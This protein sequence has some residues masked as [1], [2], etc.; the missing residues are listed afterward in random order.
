MGWFKRASREEEKSEA[1]RPARGEIEKQIREAVRIREAPS[2]RVEAMDE[3][4]EAR[5]KAKRSKRKKQYRMDR[6]ARGLKRR[7]RTLERYQ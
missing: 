2:T 1:H 4:R 7:I 3:L 5:A 6:R